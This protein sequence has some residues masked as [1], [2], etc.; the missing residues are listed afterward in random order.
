L[1]RRKG[2][3]KIDRNAIVFRSKREK[4]NEKVGGTVAEFLGRRLG[5]KKNYFI[6]E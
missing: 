2:M 5:Y 6:E 3:E 1:W 4:I